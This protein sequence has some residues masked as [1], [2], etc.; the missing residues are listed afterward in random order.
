AGERGGRGPD[1]QSGAGSAR[2]ATFN[3]MLSRG[4]SPH[5]SMSAATTPGDAQIPSFAKRKATLGRRNS[6]GEAHA[7]PPDGQRVG[8]D[9]AWLAW[10]GR[11]LATI[12][13]SLAC[14]TGPIAGKSAGSA[15]D[16]CASIR[17]AH[18]IRR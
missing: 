13:S 12:S 14:R 7:T 3:A 8:Y 16:P 5:Q 11:W 18:A 2:Q 1:E 9:P 6:V 17:A 4:G 15:G 10:P